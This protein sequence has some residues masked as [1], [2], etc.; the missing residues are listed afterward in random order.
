MLTQTLRESKKGC[1]LLLSTFHR[2]EIR[3]R[4]NT[5]S[6]DLELLKLDTVQGCREVTLLRTCLVFSLPLGSPF[7]LFMFNWSK[8]WRSRVQWNLCPV[9][10]AGRVFWNLVG[11]MHVA[12]SMGMAIFSSDHSG[13]VSSAARPYHLVVCFV[14]TGTR[15]E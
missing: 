8:S 11:V 15:Q 9:A 10:L 1:R 4:D 3:V 5:T 12:I 13:F 2:P 7:Y 6:L 14:Y